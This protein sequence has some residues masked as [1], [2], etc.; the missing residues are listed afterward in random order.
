MNPL[1][2]KHARAD[3]FEVLLP[4]IFYLLIVC[5]LVSAGGCDKPA[6][7]SAAVPVKVKVLAPEEIEVSTTFSGSIEPLQSTS[8]A[9]KLSGTVKSLYRPPGLNRGVQVGDTLAKGTVIAEFDEGDLRRSKLSAEAKVAQLEARVATARENLVIAT[10][11]F[12][13]YEEAAGAVSREARDDVERQ[14][15]DR[16]EGKRQVSQGQPAD[17]RSQRS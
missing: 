5:L 16:T 8:L 9:F 4:A 10:R 14:A 15:R 3:L 13:R 7:E 6:K 12:H 2:T 11:N 1:L 17:K